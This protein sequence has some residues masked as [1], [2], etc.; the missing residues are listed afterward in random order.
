MTDVGVFEVKGLLVLIGNYLAPCDYHNL[1]QHL[2]RWYPDWLSDSGLSFSVSKFFN[3]SY[4]EEVME[5]LQ[6]FFAST[7]MALTG[8]L[9]LQHLLMDVQPS[10][11]W[12]ANDV[13]VFGPLNENTLNAF[14]KFL[15]CIR[16]LVWYISCTDSFP[17]SFNKPTEDQKA[18]LNK[19]NSFE[20]MGPQLGLWNSTD[21][22]KMLA[23]KSGYCRH[24]PTVCYKVRLIDPAT[25]EMCT[26][27]YPENVDCSGAN[28]PCHHYPTMDFVF[29]NNT[30]GTEGTF[31]TQESVA[32]WIHQNFDLDICTS[33]M[34]GNSKS[35]WWGKCLSPEFDRI[36]KREGTFNPNQYCVDVDLDDFKISKSNRYPGFPAQGA[37]SPHYCP[38][39]TSICN[40][41]RKYRERKF[42]ILSDDT[43]SST[44]IS[45]KRQKLIKTNSNIN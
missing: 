22:R 37:F 45:H 1:L 34:F 21:A 30:A 2:G 42:T 33:V 18:C 12:K 27:R 29:I 36:M 38:C 31:G 4:P 19:I 44:T 25:R 11:S 16:P 15:E 40:R 32:D 9:V 17:T 13:D 20:F 3:E 6:T 26:H 24:L 14:H 23:E 10:T 43:K 35:G 28:H 8:S 39:P 41:I 5:A 7:N